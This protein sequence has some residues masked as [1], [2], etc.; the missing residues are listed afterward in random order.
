[1]NVSFTWDPRKSE[2]NRKHRGF[3]FLMAVRVF[4]DPNVRF[5]EDRIHD[6]EERL[7]AI[8]ALEDIGIVVVAFTVEEDEQEERYR[9]ISARLAEP[10]EKRRYYADD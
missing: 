6:G 3:D 10:R 9:I 8:G 7:H 2:W 5:D 4:D 1:M